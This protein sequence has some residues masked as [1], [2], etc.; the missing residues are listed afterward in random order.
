MQMNDL[1]EEMVALANGVHSELAAL[2]DDR[3]RYDLVK[4]IVD[5]A[6]VVFAVWTDESAQDGVGYLLVK[7]QA[8]ARQF[9]TDDT[10]VSIR[11]AAI[12]CSCAEQAEALLREL[13]ERYSRH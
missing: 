1:L 9:V 12:P 10:E 8:F 7:G 5:E 6:E 13:G 3:A 2:P 11:T 4:Q